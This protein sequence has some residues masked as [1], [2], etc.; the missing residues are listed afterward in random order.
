M[1]CAMPSKCLSSSIL[2][3]STKIIWVKSTI[4][5][6]VIVSSS[7]KETKLMWQQFSEWVKKN[8][9]AFK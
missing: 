9:H 8:G 5:K 6:S 2:R 7:N 1:I 3:I 4:M